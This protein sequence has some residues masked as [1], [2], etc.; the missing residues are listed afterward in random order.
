[1]RGWCSFPRRE[2]GGSFKLKGFDLTVWLGGILTGRCSFL[3]EDGCLTKRINSDSPPRRLPC[4][5]KASTIQPALRP[6]RLCAALGIKKEHG[7]GFGEIIK[8]GSIC[9]C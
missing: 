5:E 7:I 8:T 3:V 1:M 9:L 4:A 2:D 6:A